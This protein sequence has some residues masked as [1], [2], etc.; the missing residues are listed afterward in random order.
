MC[1]DTVISINKTYSEERELSAFDRQLQL[2]LLR[3]YGTQT[4]DVLFHL[5]VVLRSA[6][7]HLSSTMLYYTMYGEV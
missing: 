7:A 6:A 2:Q 1:T 5:S 4:M 3:I